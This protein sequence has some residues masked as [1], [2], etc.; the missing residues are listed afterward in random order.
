MTDS[1]STL[2]G[3]MISRRKFLE[4]SATSAGVAALAA[5]KLHAES[6]DVPLPPSIAA[7][8]PRKDEATPIT[9]EER[10]RRQERARKRKIRS[11]PWC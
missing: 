2:G 10:Q 1:Q 8:K 7:L 5:P 4:L 3:F 9:R 6:Q 11:T